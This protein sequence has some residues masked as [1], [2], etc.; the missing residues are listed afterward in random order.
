MLNKIK[1]KSICQERW[2]Q[3]QESSNKLKQ[4]KC[5]VGPGGRIHTEL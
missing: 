1:Y 2:L 4:S 3:L 5:L